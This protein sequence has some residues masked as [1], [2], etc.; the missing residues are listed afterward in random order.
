MG[1]ITG[2]DVKNE[3]DVACKVINI[4]NYTVSDYSVWL[5]IAVTVERYIVTVHALHSKSMCT[6]SRARIV[7]LTV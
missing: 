3:S 5:L 7:M 6:K 4:L 1:H 2:Y